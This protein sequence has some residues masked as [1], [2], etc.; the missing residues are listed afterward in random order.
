[1]S[2]RPALP[3]RARGPG[4][5]NAEA[6]RGRPAPERNASNRDV[7]EARWVGGEVG[8][9]DGGE[10]REAEFTSDSRGGSGG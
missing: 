3:A 1:M 2:E 9:V 6:G 4:A 8:R 5:R 7:F 10:R